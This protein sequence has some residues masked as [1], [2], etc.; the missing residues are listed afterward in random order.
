PFLQKYTKTQFR[1][2]TVSKVGMPANC[3]IMNNDNFYNALNERSEI[4]YS[5]HQGKI[6][7]E[8]K[9]KEVTN[10]FTF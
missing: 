2:Q 4:L 7:V 1:S 10:H 6:L 9:P 5:I 8:T 3:I